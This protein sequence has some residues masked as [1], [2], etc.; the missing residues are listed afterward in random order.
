MVIIQIQVCCSPG[1]ASCACCNQSV[2][3]FVVFSGMSERSNRTRP[4]PDLVVVELLH[5]CFGLLFGAEGDEGVTSVVPIEVHHHPHLVDLT[6][7]EI[8]RVKFKKMWEKHANLW[9][10]YIILQFPSLTFS[11]S[12]TSS[13]SNRSL[14]SF[15]TKISLPLSGGGPS[16]SGGGPPYR[17]W[18]FSWNTPPKNIKIKIRKVLKKQGIILKYES[19]SNLIWESRLNHELVLWFTFTKSTSER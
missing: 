13:S 18:P 14:G 4:W 3:L 6:K 15:P 1:D 7:L 10:N 12:G 2:V 11:H 5:G 19:T 16:Q 9:E 8:G 17:R